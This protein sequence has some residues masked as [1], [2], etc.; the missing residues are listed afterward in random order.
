MYY[1]APHDFA[2]RSFLDVTKRDVCAHSTKPLSNPEKQGDPFRT[3]ANFCNHG[4]DSFLRTTGE[5]IAHL[6]ERAQ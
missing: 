2:S 3:L 1:F 4:V 5:A 6:E